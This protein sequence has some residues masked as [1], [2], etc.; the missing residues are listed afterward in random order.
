MAYF[1][2][3]LVTSF[4]CPVTALPV[5]YKN[6]AYLLISALQ[7]CLDNTFL[8]FFCRVL[9]DQDTLLSSGTALSTGVLY[10]HSSSFH[11]IP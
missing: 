2:F 6:L 4:Y 5:Q 9:Q 1:L 8:L 11:I 7:P 3:L 10:L